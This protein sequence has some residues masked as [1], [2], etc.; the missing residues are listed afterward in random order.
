M[1]FLH[2]FNPSDSFIHPFLYLSNI[3]LI[4]KTLNEYYP[5]W[6]T[7][8]HFPDLVRCSS[9][10]FNHHFIHIFIIRVVIS[11]CNLFIWL[12]HPSRFCYPREQWLYLIHFFTQYFGDSYYLFEVLGKWEIDICKTLWKSSVQAPKGLPKL[13]AKN[14][15][16]M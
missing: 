13:M 4:F 10:I 5:I 8:I 11:H 9:S 12:P 1:P 15:R 6:K 16:I 3:C 7:F 14:K 2:L